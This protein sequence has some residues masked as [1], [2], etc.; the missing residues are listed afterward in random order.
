MLKSYGLEESPKRPAEPATGVTQEAESSSVA[1]DKL[2]E[3]MNVFAY[4]YFL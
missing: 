1:S 2:K 3:S 4:I